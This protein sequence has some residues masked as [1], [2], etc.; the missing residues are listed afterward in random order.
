MNFCADFIVTKPLLSKAVQRCW[1]GWLS[2]RCN[3]V[4]RG[5]EVKRLIRN[6]I[7]RIGESLI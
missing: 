3:I 1:T 4:A 7:R 5:R 2:P 6:G